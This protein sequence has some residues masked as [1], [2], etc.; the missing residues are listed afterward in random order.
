[1][2][3]VTVYYKGIATALESVGQGKLDR[4][5][6]ESAIRWGGELTTTNDVGDRT[7]FGGYGTW[8]GSAFYGDNAPLYGKLDQFGATM[9]AKFAHDV[10]PVGLH[11]A[12]TED[13]KFGNFLV[14]TALGDEFEDFLFPLCQTL[15]A[16]FV[17]SGMGA[18][19]VVAQQLLGHRGVQEHISTPYCP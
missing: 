3:D 16:L 2:N 8:Q 11:R 9:Q 5:C 15:Q 12:G 19:Q 18:F 13:Q 14:G 17:F 10:S 6:M 4:I 7:Q 1:M